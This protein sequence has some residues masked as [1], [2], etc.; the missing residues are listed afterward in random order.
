MSKVE[1]KSSL[2]FLDIKI[3]RINNSFST[4]IYRKV[5][6]SKVLTNFERCILAHYESNLIF[7]L[8]F[9]AFNPNKPGFFG[10]IFFLGVSV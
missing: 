4:R 2:S 3:R 5:T 7:T 10:G 1:E 6:F 9:R 8:I